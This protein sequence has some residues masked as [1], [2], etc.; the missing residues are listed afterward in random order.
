MTFKVVGGSAKVAKFCKCPPSPQRILPDTNP[1]RLRLIRQF[2]KKWV[3]GMTLKYHFLKNREYAGPK[4]YQVQSITVD[5]SI[6]TCCML[7]LH[8]AAYR[9][10]LMKL[11]CETFA[12][13]SLFSVSSSASRS[14]LIRSW[15]AWHSSDTGRAILNSYTS[16][17]E[18]STQ[19]GIVVKSRS[20]QVLQECTHCLFVAH[21]FQCLVVRSWDDD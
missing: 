4:T 11:L 1:A 21:R 12:T 6:Y 10:H 3:N 9:C 7:R 2:E 5:H 19:I 16:A 8:F 17:R 15:L 18:L 13:I 14:L 20:R